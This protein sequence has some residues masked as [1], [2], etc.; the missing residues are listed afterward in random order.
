MS[1]L[2]VG[3]IEEEDDFF[4]DDLIAFGDAQVF[5]QDDHPIGAFTFARPVG[6]GCDFLFDL[7]GVFKSPLFDDLPFDIVRF[8]AGLCLDLI[9]GGVVLALSRLFRA[10]FELFRSGSDRHHSQ[11]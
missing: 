8:L 5:F 1:G 3:D 10:I 9:F 4:L 7:F 11:R 2:I 6:E